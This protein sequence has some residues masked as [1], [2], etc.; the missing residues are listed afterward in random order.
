MQ[1]TIHVN[2]R[3]YD[4]VLLFAQ[5]NNM[6]YTAPTSS[7]F[8]CLHGFFV[9]RTIDPLSDKKCTLFLGDACISSDFDLDSL[10]YRD[11]ESTSGISV[12]F[13]GDATLIG[14]VDRYFLE[15]IWLI[16]KKVAL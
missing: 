11:L 2:V 12:G 14:R 7:F 8:L 15:S 1:N 16:S 13:C 5:R 3:L 10:L 6:C 4:S 9:H